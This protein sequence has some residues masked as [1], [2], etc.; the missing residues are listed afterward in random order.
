LF[1]A[2]PPWKFFLQNKKGDSAF[3]H[4]KELSSLLL[5][6]ATS[7]K[8]KGPTTSPAFCQFLKP[9]K[10]KPN[11]IPRNQKGQNLINL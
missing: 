6:T 11:P 9:K 10:T 1:G 4:L 5:I 8:K 3:H 2:V 7:Q